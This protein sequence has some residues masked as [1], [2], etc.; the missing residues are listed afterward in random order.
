MG[1]VMISP[2]FTAAATTTTAKTWK[3][4]KFTAVQV[5]KLDARSD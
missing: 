2:T 4:G 1:E 5:P 3:S